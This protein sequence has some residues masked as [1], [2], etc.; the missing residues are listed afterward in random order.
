[1]LQSY[2]QRVIPQN[3]YCR[4][5]IMFVWNKL[6]SR[7]QSLP[8]PYKTTT[9]SKFNRCCFFLQEITLFESCL[10]PIVKQPQWS[11]DYY[12]W[13]FNVHSSHRGFLVYNICG[14]FTKGVG[15]TLKNLFRIAMWLWN[16]C[17]RC[18][19]EESA[20]SLFLLHIICCVHK[21]SLHQWY[22]RL[23]WVLSEHEPDN[24]YTYWYNIYVP[25]SYAT[26][27]N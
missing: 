16:W 21:S 10:K 12:D 15:I 23:E 25:W 22:I 8:L 5:N 13:Y 20:R 27:D 1:M 7:L 3:K 11:L 14:F 6:I 18:T 19:Q 24:S 9:Y 17:V 2:T 26:A 4:L